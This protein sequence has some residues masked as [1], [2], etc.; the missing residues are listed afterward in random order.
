MKRVLFLLVGL[1][2]T[3]RALPPGQPPGV[4][5]Y[6]SV[7]F[8]F[9]GT[10]EALLDAGPSGRRV[11]LG[12]VKRVPGRFGTALD[13]RTGGVHVG[14][15]PVLDLT[16]GLTL[17]AWIRVDGPGDDLQRIAYRSSVY[18]LYLDRTG[19]SLT[20]YVNVG[21]EWV[22]I[23]ADVPQRRWVHIAGT[24]DGDTMRVYVDG[25]MSEAKQVGG[26]IILSR[27]PLEIGGE[28]LAQRR[29]LQGLIDA[30]RL[31]EV[32]RDD[33]ET[34][35]TF[36]PSVDATLAPIPAGGVKPVVP[37][38][39]VGLTAAAPVIDG[40][41]TDASWSTALTLQFRDALPGK[42]ITQGTVARL[43]YD[44]QALYIGVRCRESRMTKL[45][46]SVT[47]HDGRVWS[48]DCVEL[49]LR[50]GAGGS[51]YYH[52]AV[53]ALGT[54]YD[55][56]CVPGGGTDAAWQSGARTAAYLEQQAWSVEIAVPFSAL[57][58]TPA[59]GIPWR[60]NL[61][62]ERQQ[63]PE[64]SS[65]APVGGSFH[66]P[67]R[68]GRLAF[69]E[70]P[71]QPSKVTTKLTGLALGPGGERLQGIPVSSVA[72]V[73]R[74]NTRGRFVIE[75]L[76]RGMQTLSVVSPRYH[77][78][79]V[80]VNLTQPDERVVLPPVTAVDPNAL[81][82]KVPESLNGF[83]VRN[84]A[85]LD[86]LDPAVTPDSGDSD[87]M[88]RAFACPGEYEPFGVAIFAS[89][90]LKLVQVTV[91]DLAGMNGGNIPRDAIDVRIVKRCFMRT[92]YSR[93]P[94]DIGLRSRYLLP[95][96]PFGMAANTFR[97]VH[98]IVRV[99]EGTPAGLY[100]GVLAVS[101]Q[102]TGTALRAIEFEVLP[103]AL[104]RP[105]KHY[106]LYYRPRLSDKTESTIRMELADMRAHGADRLLWNPRIGYVKEEAGI[107]I[108]YSGVEQPVSLLQ[109]F[110]FDGPYVVWDGFE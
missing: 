103:I 74:S 105:R 57:G 61:G 98:A 60:F 95:A 21:G 56:A 68:F 5:E 2:C 87:S 101:A 71:T 42:P 96:Q 26:P 37:E 58:G 3:V 13:A 97:R 104:T 38:A 92:H 15:W 52:L 102:G 106:G 55:A 73:A 51:T 36:E 1:V 80:R 9:D 75:G 76:P 89:Q 50:P 108:D 44:S 8:Q 81:T 86:D 19:R 94:E 31:S 77:P 41:L 6:T 53:N 65:W 39:T 40:A 72:G 11:P 29:L 48:D 88:L 47:E 49:F 78:F 34:S 100:S 107:R 14:Y 69:G 93:P 7:L 45:S 63:G 18:G 70:Q 25:E 23:R 20:F 91:S 32:A 109:E 27:S 99:P 90:A 64:I 46:K 24:Y 84:L 33:F 82:I 17:E 79:A 43:T 28:A 10:G 110:G 54:V 35:L 66:R 85:P 62:R 67:G 22:S 12:Q 4:D 59:S 16:D 30:V 83:L